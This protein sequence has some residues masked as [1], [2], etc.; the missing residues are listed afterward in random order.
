MTSNYQARYEFVD[1]FMIMRAL[2]FSTISHVRSERVRYS[3]KYP[4]RGQLSPCFE[5]KGWQVSER[6]KKSDKPHH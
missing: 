5:R 1:F 3:V 4:V 6:L 2:V